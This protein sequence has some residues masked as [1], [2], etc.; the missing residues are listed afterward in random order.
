MAIDT[1]ERET[2][3]KSEEG[4]IRPPGYLGRSVKVVG[5]IR[6]LDPADDPHAQNRRGEL[7]KPLF[8]WYFNTISKDPI[9]RMGF[10][11]HAADKEALLSTIVGQAKLGQ[12]RP[13]RTPVD[14]PAV[15]S[16]H[17]KQALAYMGAD[18]VG[19][20]RT[21]PAYLYQDG[22]QRDTSEVLVAGH[23]ADTPDALAERYPYA[24]VFIVAWDDEMGRAHRHRIG[25]AAYFA[26]AQRGHTITANLEGYLH[27][28]GYNSR[29]GAANPMPLALLAGLGE[30]GRNGLVITEK[31]GAR[32]HPNVILTDLPLVPDKP[33]D[34]G[35]SDFCAICNK[36][37][38][39]CPTNSITHEGKVA[40]NG[41]EK[42][43]INWKTCYALR[44]FWTDLWQM[45]LTCV[46]SCP[47]T[48]R[49]TWW[50][51]AAVNL[52][53]TTPIRLR[54]LVVHPLK[55]LDDKFWGW[56]PRKRV[57]WLGYD[58]GREQGTETCNIEGCSCHK[59]N[60]PPGKQGVY[61]PLREN[62]VRFDRRKPIGKAAS[63]K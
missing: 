15:M 31:F 41:I 39:S 7:G 40:H 47:Y 18:A 53:R 34:L 51:S 60:P 8:N 29:H 62:T 28:L 2:Y 4:Y 11:T 50:R 59:E 5:P 37:A 1:S 54:P 25:D 13:E 27:E 52:L 46:A 43:K 49:N 20:A 55:W 32:M 58:S 14:D 26:G 12:V 38:I 10:L 33:I 48:K 56:I 3:G 19:I 23:E 22:A 61:T 42:Y 24:I 16:R 44:A 36:C 17:I 21:D 45:C 63:R 35:V 57:R 9:S 6:P 30:L